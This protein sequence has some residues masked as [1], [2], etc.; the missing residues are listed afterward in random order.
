VKLRRLWDALWP[1]MILWAVLVASIPFSDLDWPDDGSGQLQASLYIFVTQFLLMK[2]ILI[3]RRM[4]GY[5]PLAVSL[6]L[7]N[8]SFSFAYLLT[9]YFFLNMNWVINNLGWVERISD[10]TYVVLILILLLAIWQL[11]RLPPPGEGKQ[12]V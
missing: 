3:L 8:V 5:D 2:A 11:I 6:V 10:A 1:T 9:L 12:E 7:V 4:N